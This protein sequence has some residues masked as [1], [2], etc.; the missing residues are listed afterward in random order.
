MTVCVQLQGSGY[1]L[2]GIGPRYVHM[3][4]AYVC[5]RFI[6]SRLAAF[7]DRQDDFASLDVVPAVSCADDHAY[8][9]VRFCELGECLALLG[10]VRRLAPAAAAATAGRAPRGL[11]VDVHDV[12][13]VVADL[14][15][16][17]RR[18]HQVHVQHDDLFSEHLA[19][20]RDLDDGQV[21]EP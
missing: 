20:V 2:H 1:G 9:V 21:V 10:F 12:R 18:I 16:V 13:D 17:F 7:V 6:L 19:C 11:A 15:L 8:H 5:S 14:Q 4:G 3:V